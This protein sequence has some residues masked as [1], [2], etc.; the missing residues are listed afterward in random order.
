MQGTANAAK[1]GAVLL[2]T[3]GRTFHP[4]LVKDSPV[5]S[6]EEIKLPNLS[7]HLIVAV[8]VLLVESALP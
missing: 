1:A 5:P 6:I 4:P 8:A 3:F 7:N 2:I